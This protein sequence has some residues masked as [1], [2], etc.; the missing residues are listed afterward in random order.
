M[1][2][3]ILLNSR[4]KFLLPEININ[5]VASLSELQTAVFQA[6]YKYDPIKIYTCK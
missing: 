6:H 2:I 4:Q 5:D 3:L 1:Q